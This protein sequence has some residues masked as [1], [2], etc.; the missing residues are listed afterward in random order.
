MKRSNLSNLI[1]ASAIGLSLAILPLAL[2]VS[3]QT[4]TTPGT[5]TTTEPVQGTNN[6]EQGDRDFDWGWLGLIGL[7]GLAGLSR[8][9]EAPTAYRDPNVASTTPG[10]RE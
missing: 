10:Y 5:T 1:G 7:A 6:A 3:A 4:D 8:K 9:N 2:P